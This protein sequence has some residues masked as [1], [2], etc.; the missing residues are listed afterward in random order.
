M[1]PDLTALLQDK[2]GQTLTRYA[3]EQLQES[4]AASL[5]AVAMTLPALLGEL[6]KNHANDTKM[7]ALFNLVTGPRLADSSLEQLP[8]PEM[9]GQLL[10][11]TLGDTAW[12]NSLIANKS[13]VSSSNASNLLATA[14]PLILGVLRSH[15]QTNNLT[16]PQFVALLAS[17]K[18]FLDNL[19]SGGFLGNMG[20]GAGLGAAA[21]TTTGNSANA[22]KA[23]P[24]TATP[25]GSGIPKWLWFAA[26]GLITASL[27]TFCSDKKPTPESAPGDTPASHAEAANVLPAPET[28]AQSASASAIAASDINLNAVADTTGADAASPAVAAVTPIS[29]QNGGVKY[30][31]GILS[32]Y[33][34]TGKTDFDTASAEALATDIVQQGKEG[35]VLAVSGFHDPRGNA[36]LNAELSKKRAQAVRHFLITQGVPEARIELVK[37][38]ETTDH[39]DSNAENRRVDVRVQ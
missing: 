34:A 39:A 14:F 29:M 30:E 26:V 24:T 9:G 31:N 23:M 16:Q 6:A 7:T 20:M 25:N 32:V 5:K 21:A 10:T 13:G 27:A 17:Q 3:T 33:F 35:K 12:L 37:P 19:L 2:V 1:F 38:N 28:T 8:S 36:R 22:N 15:I 18:S 4:P 11:S